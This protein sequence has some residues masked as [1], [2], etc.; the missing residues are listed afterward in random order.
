MLSSRSSH[1]YQISESGINSNFVIGE[2]NSLASSENTIT[3]EIRNEMEEKKFE[4]ENRATA[5][6]N[7]LP[8]SLHKVE[9]DTIIEK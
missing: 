8:G 7:I 4:K 6:E 9:A 3:K 5:T 1:D 2:E